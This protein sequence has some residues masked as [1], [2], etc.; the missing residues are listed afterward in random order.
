MSASRTAGVLLHPTS[1]PPSTDAPLIGDLGSGAHAFIDWLADAGSSAWQMLPI[2]PVGAGN[3]PYC[4]TSSFA[5]EPML[6][7]LEDLNVT[8]TS[9]VDWERTRA[10]KNAR[11]RAMYT[12]VDLEQ[13]A[14]FAAF[15]ASNAHWL[16]DFCGWLGDDPLYHAF[17]Q[18]LLD[19]QW[20]KLKAHAHARGIA[21]IGDLPIFV[22]AASAD[23]AARPELFRLNEAGEPTVVTGVPPDDFAV[24]GQ[25]WGHPHYDWPVHQ[26]EHFAWWRNRVHTA[27]TR[28]DALR[29]DHFIGFVRTY[30]INATDTHARNGTWKETPGRELLSALQASLGPLP[31][32]AEDLGTLTQEVIDLRR[33]FGLPGMAVLQWSVLEPTPPQIPADTVVYPGTHDNDTTAGWWA[34]LSEEERRLATERIGTDPVQGLITFALMCP[35]ERA[36]VQAQDLLGLGSDARM[37]RPGIA[38]GNW[39][40]RVEPNALNAEVA[41]HFRAQIRDSRP[42]PRA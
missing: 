30:E 16:P 32:I 3:S 6:V 8:P 38:S 41:A 15:T 21:L 36:I 4:S 2:G 26:A 40:W 10:I 24:D 33:E 1:L 23:V 19:G 18:F 34:S 17:V 20:A 25:R 13:H 28:F 5:I 14:A 7:A 9:T 11:L 42:N 22:G 37:N 39:E 27:L 12:A 35:A 31:F 29:I